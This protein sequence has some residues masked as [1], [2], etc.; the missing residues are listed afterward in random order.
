MK[1]IILLILILLLTGCSVKYDVTITDTEKIKEKFVIPV[2]KDT[3]LKE[4]KTVDEY[5]DYYSN[6]YSSNYAYQ[7]FT[8]K[9][10]KGKKISNFV[11]EREYKNLDEYIISSSFKSIY[12]KANIERIGKYIKFTTTKN[13]YLA[14]IEG[15]DYLD[16]DF[17]YTDFK[18]NIRF[19]NK[20]VD[21][22]ADQIDEKNNIYTWDILSK[23]TDQYIMFKISDEKRYDVMFKDFVLNN[24]LAIISFGIIITGAIIVL[25]YINFERVKNNKI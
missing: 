11:V 1:K 7:D 23:G 4:F 9:T 6:L 19:F 18:V 17:Q 20:V 21:S 12:D 10:K 15:D 25:I 2:E 5:L 16:A 8:I 3:M 14:S 24:L 13:A 22:N